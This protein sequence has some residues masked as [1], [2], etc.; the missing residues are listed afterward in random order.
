MTP[1]SPVFAAFQAID[2]NITDTDKNFSF[3][4]HT[5][6]LRDV[7]SWTKKWTQEN[8]KPAKQYAQREWAAHMGKEAITAFFASGKIE[9][10]QK[11]ITTISEVDFANA[12]LQQTL[13]KAHLLDILTG[14]LDRNVG[15][16]IYIRS[17]DGKNWDAKLIDND[18]SFPKQFHRPLPLFI[19]Q[20]VANAITG[21]DSEKLRSTL[22]GASLSKNEIEAT[23]ERLSAL[24]DHI[25]IAKNNISPS[26]PKKPRIVREWNEGTFEEQIKTPNN[27]IQLAYEAKKIAASQA[28]KSEE[29]K[30]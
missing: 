1:Q 29:E 6:S 20:E 28:P 21:L 30:V 7:Q 11:V 2:P 3:E 13:S 12:R 8:P 27:Y 19:D 25:E 16:F 22:K 24:K 4:F 23:L 14:Q 26:D 17:L 18:V 10:T 9:A 15:N 5:C